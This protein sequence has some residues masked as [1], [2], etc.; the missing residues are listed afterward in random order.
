MDAMAIIWG[1]T[2]KQIAIQL[3]V[4]ECQLTLVARLGRNYQS[5]DRHFSRLSNLIALARG[6]NSVYLTHCHDQLVIGLC[7]I[8]HFGHFF[9][10]GQMSL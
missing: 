2:F 3:R 10:F 8:A 6:D 4:R 7:F 5:Q 9:I 1:R